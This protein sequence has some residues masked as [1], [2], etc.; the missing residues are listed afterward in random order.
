MGNG[1]KEM[2]L[3]NGTIVL[4]YIDKNGIYVLKNNKG[5]EG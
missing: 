5:I 2:G 4:L 1:V 3:E